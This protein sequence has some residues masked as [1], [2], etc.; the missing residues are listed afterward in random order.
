MWKFFVKQSNQSTLSDDELLIAYKRDGKKSHVGVLYER[1]AQHLFGFCLKYL[2]DEELA[3]D[4]VATI[5]SKLFDDL[6]RFEIKNLKG[7]LLRVAYNKCMD[8]LSEEK[9]KTFIED[10]DWVEEDLTNEEFPM[11]DSETLKQALRQLKK[12]H[13]LCLE[14]FYLDG[15]SYQAVSEQS[16]Y[17]LCEVKSYI[18]NGKRNLLIYFQTHHGESKV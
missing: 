5:F 4:V 3:K 7:W 15:K 11:P 8:R 14:M 10:K 13:K 9:K 18:Q 17:T 2:K 1:Y 12:E 6:M 16:G